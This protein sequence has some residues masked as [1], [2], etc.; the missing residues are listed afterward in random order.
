VNHNRFPKEDHLPDWAR[1]DNQVKKGWS[2]WEATSTPKRETRAE[3]YNTLDYCRLILLTCDVMLVVI[4]G[5][6]HRVQ[7]P[8]RPA[9]MS[10][11]LV[12][13]TASIDVLS[14][15]VHL[16]I[17]VEVPV[18][19]PAETRLERCNRHQSRVGPCHDMQVLT[20]KDTISRGH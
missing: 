3:H 5:E 10:A 20:L 19:T 6:W 17:P 14:Q 12:V 18:S 4:V 13:V 8:C 7:G 16:L 11:F 9:S 2:Y 1:R 15:V